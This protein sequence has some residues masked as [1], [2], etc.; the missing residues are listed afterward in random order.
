MLDIYCLDELASYLPPLIDCNLLSWVEFAY[1]DAHTITSSVS[2]RFSCK[3]HALSYQTASHIISIYSHQFAL[4]RKIRIVLS[5][6]CIIFHNKIDL[7]FVC[8][9]LNCQTLTAR[10]IYTLKW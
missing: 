4:T 2:T 1:D 3:N 6:S 10:Y 5:R 7:Q 9:G 8:I